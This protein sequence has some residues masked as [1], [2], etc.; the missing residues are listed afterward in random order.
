[1]KAAVI[2]SVLGARDDLETF[3]L[4]RRA[5]FSGVEIEVTR[6][7]LRSPGRQ[8]LVGLRRA[9]ETTGLAIP[10]L[11]LGQHNEGGVA[12]PSPEVAEP[13]AEDVRQA[14]DWAATLGADAV[15][16]P[17]FL[18]AEIV[19]DAGLERCASAFRALAPIGRAAGV[20]L[21]YEG[22]LPADRI[23]ALSA[24]I[25][26]DAFGC[27]FDL[28]NPISVGLDAP[29]EIRALAGLVRRV[30][31]KDTRVTR[32]DCRP[33]LGRVD[34]AESARALAEIGYDGWLV[35]E[36][37]PGLP[38]LVARDLSFARGIFRSLAAPAWP[39]FGAFSYEFA[40]GEW[41]RLADTF[42]LL[43]L[44]A[45]QLGTGLLEECLDDPARI[46][47]L[48]ARLEDDGVAIV[49]LAGYRNL[50]APDAATRR[51]SIEFLTRCLEVA[52][53]F[54]T[55]VVATETGTRNPQS[56]WADSPAN[57]SENAW[58]LLVEAI[59]SLLPVA[60]GAGAILALEAHVSNVL[61]TRAQLI[62]LLER[63]P[64]PHLQIV[65][66]PY[67]YLSR[68]LVPA[69]EHVTAAFLDRFEHRFVL[70]HL[71]DVAPEGAEASTPEF[72]A[73]VF[74]QRPYLEFLRTRRPDLPLI[75]EHLP[76]ERIPEAIRRVRTAAGRG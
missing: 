54:G 76:L 43:G 7:D 28:G 14:I 58:R 35:L 42:R 21:C 44:E 64:S 75:V 5:G 66:D 37:P 17:F 71:K 34:F 4:A 36:T 61:K 32:G 24:R 29:T 62:D 69:H 67:N 33:G 46:A 13:A 1:M 59:D 19:D 68:D 63:F 41:D 47:P 9:Q 74:A 50:V 11:L 30:H 22:T 55:S 72:G 45:V 15:L 48:R 40:A 51:G 73:G 38:E 6:D 10:S 20:T 52:R 18:T 2:D 53:L 16:V 12:H 25:G 31:F 65:C 57:R 56:D 26:S 39:R 60:E 8:R 3:R 49:G 70:A 23:R 27:Y